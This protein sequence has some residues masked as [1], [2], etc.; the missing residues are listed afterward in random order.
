MAH[1][2]VAVV[3]LISC[4]F[5]S[6]PLLFWCA[7]F[8]PATVF[9]ET[10]AALSFSC[11]V[12]IKPTAFAGLPTALELQRK[13]SGLGSE[14]RSAG[15]EAESITAAAAAVVVEKMTRKKSGGRISDATLCMI[16]DRF[17]PS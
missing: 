15:K 17:A 16:M 7:A 3:Q 10:A 12:P 2:R 13:G 11:T 1:K 6:L 5:R 4:P 8:E 14:V 9:F